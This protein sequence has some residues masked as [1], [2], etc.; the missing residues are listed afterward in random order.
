MNKKKITLLAILG[1]IFFIAG[2]YSGNINFQYLGIGT[3]LSGLI[4]F[5]FFPKFKEI[6]SII[7]A[8]IVLHSG[9]LL[10]IKD[11]FSNQKLL[12]FIVFTI[13]I[14]FVLNSGFSDYMKNRKK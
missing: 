6:T 14:V 4:F 13:G 12:G 1:A 8:L 9:V 7:L 5:T 10:M 2:I 11:T 3:W